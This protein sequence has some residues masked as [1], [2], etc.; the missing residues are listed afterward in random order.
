MGEFG[1]AGNNKAA[2]LKSFVNALD[3][4]NIS[5]MVWQVVNPGKGPADFEVRLRPNSLF[6]ERSLIFGSIDL[7]RRTGLASYHWRSRQ[8]VAS[9]S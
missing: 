9:W 7:D 2:I 3:A 8:P 6:F 1:A 5:W 4:S